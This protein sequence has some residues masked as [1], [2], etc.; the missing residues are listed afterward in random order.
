MCLSITFPTS[1]CGLRG[2]CKHVL[3]FPLSNCSYS[4]GIQM[5]AFGTNVF[6]KGFSSNN[7]TIGKYI[8]SIAITM[9]WKNT[10]SDSL[11]GVKNTFVD[12]TFEE[13][14]NMA[15][16]KFL[17]WRPPNDKRYQ[18]NC[19]IVYGYNSRFPASSTMGLSSTNLVFLNLSTGD[20][21]SKQEYWFVVTASN[22]TFTLQMT[23]MFSKC[24]I[25]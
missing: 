19:S 18:S 23:G 16:C 20:I 22:G 9:S 5:S 14:F 1:A 7:F 8:K 10:I 2:I 17:Q 15:I 25:N 3:N 11:I 13:N 21:P 6:R 12:V 4:I 24:C